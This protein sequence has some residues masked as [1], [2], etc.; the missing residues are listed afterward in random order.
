[1]LVLLAHTVAAPRPKRLLREHSNQEH[2]FYAALHQNGGRA[3]FSRAPKVTSKRTTLSSCCLRPHSCRCAGR[4]RCDKWQLRGVDRAA[5]LTEEP[6]TKSAA[7]R[8]VHRPIDHLLAVV[9]G[10]HANRRPEDDAFIHFNRFR[11]ACHRVHVGAGGLAVASIL[12]VSQSRERK[13]SHVGRNDA[14]GPTRLRIRS[15]SSAC[16]LKSTSAERT[17]QTLAGGATQPAKVEPIL[18]RRTDGC[19]K[20]MIFARHR[21]HALSVQL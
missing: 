12:F 11:S 1:M 8:G 18:H 4:A 15:H 20:S 9:A 21:S 6:E 2:L 10:R 17:L 13:G 14:R 3:N 5:A 19:W 16:L 7:A